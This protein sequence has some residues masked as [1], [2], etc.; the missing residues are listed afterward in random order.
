MAE[1]VDPAAWGAVPLDAP[2]GLTGA[3][4]PQ[5]GRTPL[6]ITIAPGAPPESSADPSDWGALPAPSF[7]QRFQGD[8]PVTTGASALKGTKLTII[9]GNSYVPAQDAQVD[10]LIH[11][12]VLCRLLAFTELKFSN[13][14]H[15]TKRNVEHAKRPLA[16]RLAGFIGVLSCAAPMSEKCASRSRW[17]GS[18]SEKGHYLAIDFANVLYLPFREATPSCS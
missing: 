11:T 16:V 17:P 1:T 13:W 5:P 6:R 4:S 2:A 18:A 14:G 9:G 8:A 15:I 10:A 3:S 7:D 12:G